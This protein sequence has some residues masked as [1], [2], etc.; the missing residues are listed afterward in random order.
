MAIDYSVTQ[1]IADVETNIGS[2]DNN[3]FLDDSDHINILNQALM[4]EL[5]PELKSVHENYFV[6]YTD[7][8]V[9]SGTAAYDIP[10]D[11]IGGTLKSLHQ[12]STDGTTLTKLDMLTLEDVSSGILQGS[13]Y[14]FYVTG[15]QW[16]LFPTPT[17]DLTIRVWYHKRPNVLVTPAD[18]G[19]VASVDTV[20]KQ[21]TMAATLPSSWVAGVTLDV[22]RATPPFKTVL[23][24]I[25]ITGTSSK[26]VVVDDV[27][28]IQ[29]G[30]TVAE[31][32]TS[33]IPQI[34]A[35]LH[36]LLTQLGTVGALKAKNNLEAAEVERARY[37]EMASERFKIVTP[38]VDD[39]LKRITSVG[40]ISAYVHTNYPY[41]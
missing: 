29:V 40:N 15:N 41:F 8:A 33:I 39:S 34:P 14:G 18:G 30:D 35:E 23:S 5:V 16:T 4:G 20:N 2:P 36:P 7:Q 3:N 9:T 12:V 32:G 28:G 10:S 25:T 31:A 13:I 19:T 24:G 1:I 21:F 38:R 26:T 27:T 11:A 37:G 6:T 22:V 17:S